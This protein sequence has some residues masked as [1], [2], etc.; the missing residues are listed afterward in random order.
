MST[1]NDSM[2]SQDPAEVARRAVLE[3]AVAAAGVGTFD[4][5]LR[6]GVL[7]WDEPLLTLFGYDDPA[8]FDRTIEAFNA[9]VH[10]DDRTRVDELVRASIEACSD[11]DA[12]YRV[13]RPSGETVWVHARGRTLCDPTGRAVRLLGAAFDTTAHREGDARVARVMDSMSTAFFALD[14]D[15]RFSFL[16]SEAE[17]V[18]GRSRAELLGAVVW[19]EFPLALGTEFET[20][21][22]HAM[23]S[24]ESVAFDAHYPEPLNAWYEV[25]AWPNPDGLA[26]YFLDI[27]DRRNAEEQTRRAISRA[28]LLGRITEALS[29]SI[30]PVHAVS[31]LSRLVV[32]ALADWAVVTLIDDAAVS[33]TRAGLS[34]AGAWHV[35]PAKR[36]LTERY[37]TTRLS[38]MADDGMVVRAVELGTEQLIDRGATD[39][40]AAMLRP[41]EARDAVVELAPEAA[42]VL[43]LRGS[44]RPVGM[45]SLVNGRDR[46]SFS[47]D[48][49]AF[50]R[51][52]AARAGLVLD[53]S[54]L[55]RQQRDVAEGLTRSLLTEPPQ[56][57]HLQIAVRYQPAAEATRVGGDWYDAFLQADGSAV[58]VIGDVMGHDMSA[59]AAMGQVRTLVRGVAALSG[60]RPAEVLAQVDRVMATL[61]VDTTATAV[62]ARLELDDVVAADPATV[63]IAAAASE[64]GAAASGRRLQLRWSNAG[65]P[66]PMLLDTSGAATALAST[67]DLLLGVQ[68]G[69]GRSEHVTPLAAPATVLLYTDGLVERRDE[70]ITDGVERLRRVVEQAAGLDLEVLCDEVLRRMLPDRP[71]DD[72]ALV[73]VRVRA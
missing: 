30:E 33:G 7:E 6:T 66:P 47:D 36:D 14:R 8:A 26:V 42:L 51:E 5:D 19:D 71:D 1:D 48:D 24:G 9:R 16:N 53:R 69:A 65:H 67:P 3:A 29:A 4:W 20:S 59:A 41:S 72:V 40:L 10:P 73:A 70:A 18:L 32:P 55:Y 28:S 68:P 35:D 11:Y 64:P 17:R 46:G 37:A 50:A 54:R 58:L 57:D 62:V 23:E 63:A 61:R 56:T 44:L 43:P 52:V 45:L 60:G 39:L 49:L 13:V 12:E 2:A 34:E 31:E 38:V 25:R 27:T 22:R 15:W 21:Y